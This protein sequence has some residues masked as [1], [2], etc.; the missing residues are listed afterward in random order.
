MHLQGRS[1][2][3]LAR[4]MT[5]LPQLTTS[6]RVASKPALEQLVATQA[7]LRAV[8]DE[9]GSTGRVLLRYSGTEAKLRVMVEAEDRKS[10]V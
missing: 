10:V 2:N 3:E 4:C 8:E 6:Y 5:K 9:L 7:Q 1:L